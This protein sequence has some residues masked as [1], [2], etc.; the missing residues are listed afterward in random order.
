MRGDEI[1]DGMGCSGLVPSIAEK[2]MEQANQR[3]AS[4]YADLISA[5]QLA[6]DLLAKIPAF[7]DDIG[8][9]VSKAQLGVAHGRLRLALGK[10]HMA[11]KGQP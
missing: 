6:A 11:E 1:E 3:E 2:R 5:A 7:G 9:K 10:L 8:K 4:K